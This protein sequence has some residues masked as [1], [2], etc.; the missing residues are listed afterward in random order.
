MAERC[1]TLDALRLSRRD[2]LLGAGALACAQGF[3]GAALADETILARPIPHS[4]EMLPV[5]GLGTAVNFD[6]DADPGKR[7]DLKRVVSA[8]AA[9]GGTVIDTS[10]DYGRAEEVVGDLVAELALRPRLFIATKIRSGTDARTAQQEF[11][12]SLKRLRTDR[13]DLLQLHNV[14]DPHQSLAQLRDW[15]AA[16]LCR[17]TGVTSTYRRDYPAMEAIIRR[18]KPDFVQVEYSLGEREAEERIIP[19]SVEAGAGVITALPFGRASLFAAVRG[20]ALPDWAKEFGAQSFAQFFLKFLLGNKAI[21]AVIPG[22]NKTE[23]M[24]DDL[25]AGRGRLPD[26]AERARMLAFWQSLN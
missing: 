7:A 3:G 12:R 9:G 2:A 4:G 13:V 21:S 15:Q 25:G 10:T 11:E 23:H 16:K 26:E 17:Y 8:L 14:A 22:T 1:P 24:T 5:V 18:E 19:A 20:K 6:V